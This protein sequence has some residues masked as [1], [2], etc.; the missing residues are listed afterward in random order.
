MILAVDNPPWWATALTAVA[1]GAV[2]VVGGL[3]ATFWTKYLEMRKERSEFA[4][5]LSGELET[6]LDIMVKRDYLGSLK[7]A[8]TQME[9]TGEMTPLQFSVRE[10][11]FAVTPVQDQVLERVFWTA[12]E[13]GSPPLGNNKTTQFVA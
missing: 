6:I 2:A 7:L 1:G 3:V 8:I 13:K 10:S 4:S 9:L 5:A 11:F 12:S